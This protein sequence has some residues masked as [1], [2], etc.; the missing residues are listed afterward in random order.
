[1][2][3]QMR[4]MIGIGTP[5]AQSNIE[6]IVLPLVC[7]TGTR[8]QPEPFPTRHAF[9]NSLLSSAFARSSTRLRRSGKFL[10]ARLM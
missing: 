5:I 3:S 9:P 8:A 2:K 7:R 10:P 6:R 1:M 4:R